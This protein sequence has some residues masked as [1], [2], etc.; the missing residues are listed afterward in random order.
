MNE[1]IGD[2]GKRRKYDSKLADKVNKE[3]EKGTFVDEP[4]IIVPTNSTIEDIYNGYKEF[5]MDEEHFNG[6]YFIRLKQ[7][8]F[9]VKE[10]KLDNNLIWK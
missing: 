2:K 7:L 10:N 1:I 9:L 4:K 3:V 6:K 5:G 8:D